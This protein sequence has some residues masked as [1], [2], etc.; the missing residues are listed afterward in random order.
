MKN[1]LIFLISVFVL[2]SIKT[3]AQRSFQIK[4][5]REVSILEVI[6]TGTIKVNYSLN[7]H[8]VSTEKN[9]DLHIL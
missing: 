6:D 4:I 9:D 8:T 2:I 1:I 3:E 5:P 7:K